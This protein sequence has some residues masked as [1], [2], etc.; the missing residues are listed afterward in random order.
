MMVF[1]ELLR[2]IS[3]SITNIQESSEL[4][5]VLLS[6]PGRLS[7]SSPSLELELELELEGDCSGTWGEGAGSEYPGGERELSR[8]EVSDLWAG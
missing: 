6:A 8:R 3:L 1:T 5:S 7:A 4:P 2:I